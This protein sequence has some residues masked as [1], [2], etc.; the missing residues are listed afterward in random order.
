MKKP[1]L[2][3]IRAF[4]LGARAM[5]QL[6]MTKCGNLTESLQEGLM[7]DGG[8]TAADKKAMNHQVDAI[9]EVERDIGR[10]TVAKAAFYGSYILP[11]IERLQIKELFPDISETRGREKPPQ[12][13]ASDDRPESP[14]PLPKP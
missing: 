12:T 10:E 6:A 8:L 4:E 3:R 7:T 2:T 9:N 14:H 13:P 5:K 11:D 1:R